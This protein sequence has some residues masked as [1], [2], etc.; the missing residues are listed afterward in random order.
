MR[1]AESSDKGH[2]SGDK[3]KIDNAQETHCQSFIYSKKFL[4]LCAMVRKG[5]DDEAALKGDV[6]ALSQAAKRRQAGHLCP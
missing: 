2:V 1:S 5:L 4:M 6:A 3:N